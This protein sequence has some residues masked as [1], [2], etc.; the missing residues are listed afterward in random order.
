MPVMT[1]QGGHTRHRHQVEEELGPTRVPLDPGRVGFVG[2]AQL[3][4][5]LL[6]F[7]PRSMK[8]II[9]VKLSSMDAS[10]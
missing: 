3:A 8:S 6:A 4:H 2:G 10:A 1:R 7:S 5:G 9:Q